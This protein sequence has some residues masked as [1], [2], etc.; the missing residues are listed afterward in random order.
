MESFKTSVR[1]ALTQ[2]LPK[3]ANDEQN[4][5]LK[6]YHDQV[7]LFIKEVVVPIVHREEEEKQVEHE[8]DT[9]KPQGDTD[10]VAFLTKDAGGFSLEDVPKYFAVYRQGLA[11]RN[12]KTPFNPIETT[13]ETVNKIVD[14]FDNLQIDQYY[15]HTQKFIQDSFV[16]VSTWYREQTLEILNNEVFTKYSPDKWFTE[17][18][19]IKENLNTMP[20][21]A[22]KVLQ[23]L[24]LFMSGN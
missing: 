7:E 19:A 16:V 1:K 4:V 8:I 12:K 14:Y 10:P 18:E 23:R 9:S 17:M 20:E 5:V 6:N 3:S 24:Q 22:Q 11:S 2:R 13:E 15:D 21:K